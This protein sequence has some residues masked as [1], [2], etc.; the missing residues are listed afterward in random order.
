M[1]QAAIPEAL[2]KGK[3]GTPEFRAALRDGMEAQK[4]LVMCHGIANMTP[5]DHNGFDDRAR[6]MVTIQDGTWKLLP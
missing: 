1:L 3:P 4:N 6:V 2:K 5:T